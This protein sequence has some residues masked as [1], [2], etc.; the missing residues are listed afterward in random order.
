MAVVVQPAAHGSANVLGRV[1]EAL[2]RAALVVVPL[3]VVMN[4]PR[5]VAPLVADV[6]NAQPAVLAMIVV[7]I[8]VVGTIGV[9]LRAM[10]G[11][12]L[13]T[14]A[15]RDVSSARSDRASRLPNG[16]LRT[17]AKRMMVP[18]RTVTIA[19]STA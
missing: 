1:L 13:V 11:L 2:A 4:G 8:A 16:R 12:R 15:R 10:R 18:A 7:V 9:R 3:V 6:T 17:S 19:T 14:R 5:V